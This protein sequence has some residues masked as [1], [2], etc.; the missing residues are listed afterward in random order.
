M[1]ALTMIGASLVTVAT[2]AGAGSS[3]GPPVTQVILQAPK[4]YTPKAPPGGGTDDYHC[5]LLN[6]N[7]KKNALI[8]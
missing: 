3:S 6:P 4:A 5:T 2:V 7:L 1:A 8:T